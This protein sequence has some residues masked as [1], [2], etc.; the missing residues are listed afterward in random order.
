MRLEFPR[1]F[2]DLLQGTRE[3]L[4]NDIT[5]K[6]EVIKICEKEKAAREPPMLRITSICASHLMG[7][8]VKGMNR[9]GRKDLGTFTQ[10]NQSSKTYDRSHSSKLGAA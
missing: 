3:K 4:I 8:M 7:E 1:I 6:L 9:H 10:F 2:N 5:L